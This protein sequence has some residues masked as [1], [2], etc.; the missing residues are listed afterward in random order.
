MGAA[1]A[2]DLFSGLATEPC[3]LVAVSGGPDSVA[4]L[5][6]LAEWTREPGRPELHAATIDHGLRAASSAEAQAVA[7]LCGRLSIPHRILTW[8]GLKPKT[9]LQEQARAA[10]YALLAE[11]AERLGGAVVVTA[12]TLDDQAETL[13][14]RMARGSGPAGL[15]AMRKRVRRGAM[16]IARPLL[17]VP[18]VRLIATAEARGIAFATDPSN[19]DPR[20]ERVRWRA[21]MPALAEEGL[22]AQRLAVLAR[23]I[24]RLDEAATRRAQTVLSDLLLQDDSTAVVRLRFAALLGEPE[25]I[26]LRVVALALAEIDSERGS[27]QRLERLE[28]CVQALQEAAQTGRRM[29]RTLAGSVMTLSPRGILSLAREGPRRRGIHPAAS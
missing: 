18:K 4:L 23:R 8:Q 9:A 6:L 21:L 14:M 29:V 3:L 15:A 11:E 22:D 20:F 24:A 12:H 19:G 10:R 17:G 27:G 25:E 28:A 2:A 16:T 5:A 7:A 13:L 1:E 26:V